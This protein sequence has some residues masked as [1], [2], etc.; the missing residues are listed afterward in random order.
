[1]NKS[2]RYCQTFK[3]NFLRPFKYFVDLILI[4]DNTG[5]PLT[6]INW[7]SSNSSFEPGDFAE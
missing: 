2:P 7:T 1:M 6:W 4:T 3:L 5:H